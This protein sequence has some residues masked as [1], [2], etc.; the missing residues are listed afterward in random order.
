MRDWTMKRLGFCVVFGMATVASAAQWVKSPEPG[1]PQFRGPCRNGVSPE[2][3]LL[4][5]WPEGGPKVLWTAT[6]L[7]AGYSSPIIVGQTVY[8]TGDVGDE[9]HIFALVC[10]PAGLEGHQ[11]RQLEESLP[12]GARELHLFRGRIYHL[13][14]TD[15]WPVSTPGRA[16]PSGR[17]RW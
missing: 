9:L 3:G 11:R 10:R 8:L 6:N 5:S 7:G 16:A 14:G 17:A 1:W 15:A 2:T 13:N 12:W 4:Q